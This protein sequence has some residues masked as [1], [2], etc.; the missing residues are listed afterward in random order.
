MQDLLLS[1][2]CVENW[3]E[4]RAL[5]KK[6]RESILGLG[7]FICIYHKNLNFLSGLIVWGRQ[8]SHLAASTLANPPKFE[9]DWKQAGTSS[10]LRV[11]AWTRV[12]FFSSV[13]IL[14][15]RICQWDGEIWYVLQYDVTKP[16]MNKYAFHCQTLGGK[17][18]NGKGKSRGWLRS[19]L[20]LAIPNK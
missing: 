13:P 1:V 14:R 10:M 15:T 18:M 8:K 17:L 16:N 9:S 12:F 5:M 20:S 11:H 3:R 6:N 2:D 7:R 4:N 19:W